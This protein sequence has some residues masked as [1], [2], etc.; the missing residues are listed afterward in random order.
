VS[1]NTRTQSVT[2]FVW[3]EGLPFDPGGVDPRDAFAQAANRFRGQF[4]LHMSSGTEHVLLRDPLGVNKLFFAIGPE[5]EVAVSNYLIDHV[6]AGRRLQDVW[7]VPSGHALRFDTASRDY[8]LR[9]YDT[10]DFNDG[11]APRDD[12]YESAAAICSSLETTI[13]NIRPVAARRPL[14]VTMS[15]GLDST[16]VAVLTREIIGDFTG[17][18]FSMAEA[19]GTVIESDDLRFVR[20]LAQDLGV[21]LRIV[22]RTAKQ[23]LELLDDVLIYGQDW[24]DFNVHCGLVNA[25]IGL[26]LGRDQTARSRPLLLTGDCANELTADYAPLKYR[27]QTYYALP[28]L[29]PGRLRRFLVAGLDTGDREVGIFAHFGCDV[30]QPYALCAASFARVPAELLN[31][32]QAKQKLMERAVAGRVPDYILARPKVRAQSG[33]SDNSGGTL[34]AVADAGMDSQALAA[35]FCALFKTDQRTLR[36]LIKAGM[37]RFS[38]QY[39]ESQSD[40]R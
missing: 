13:R 38:M 23:L 16:T 27:G 10:L 20:R 4:A 28:D 25:A 24:R 37:Y 35:R 36:G 8:Q 9:R 5:G 31:I 39:P 32:P 40:E 34:A 26:D 6:R 7:S 29:P 2:N 12:P 11:P 3:R 33:S 19:D 17:V 21:R 22:S 1:G 14:Y 18:T 15:G 30:L